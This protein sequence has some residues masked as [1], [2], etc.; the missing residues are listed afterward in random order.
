MKAT[1]VCSIPGC[2]LVH[3]AQSYCRT[4]YSALRRHGS[5]YATGP[6]LG[7]T[8]TDRPCQA[9]GCD[10]PVG[11][12]GARGWCYKYYV[13]W[14]VQ[15]D[16]QKLGYVRGEDNPASQRIG[17]AHPLWVGD[18]ASY[19]LLHQRIARER[20]KACESPCVTCGSKAADWAYDY[21]DPKPK[22]DERTGLLYSL[23][24]ARYRP[25][26]KSCHKL[27]DLAHGEEVNSCG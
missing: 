1:R 17:K 20:G 24:V 27:H 16:P 6:V 22:T 9:V 4:H 14:K 25:M 11:R 23:D 19:S 18:E 12:S 7:P 5:P 10:R 13:R 26:C 2:D 8:R 21:T 15:G 3:E